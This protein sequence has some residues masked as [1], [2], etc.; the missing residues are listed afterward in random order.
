MQQ[1]VDMKKALCRIPDTAPD[2][3][4]VMGRLFFLTLAVA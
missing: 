2:T 4:Y 1:D 3:L